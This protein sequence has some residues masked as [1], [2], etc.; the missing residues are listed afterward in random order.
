MEQAVLG[1]IM[2]EKSAMDRVTDIL[3]PES[4][5]SDA[6]QKVFSAIKS[7]SAKGSPIDLLTVVEELTGSGDLDAVGGVGAVVRLTNSVVSS[8]H[9]EAHA[10]VIDSYHVRREVIRAAGELINM[11]YDDGVS[12]K[13]LIEE[14]DKSI[15]RIGAGTLSTGIM[16]MDDVMMSTLEKVDYWRNM[17]SEVTGVPSG[18]REIDYSTRGW[19]PGDLI[20]LAARPSVGKTALSLN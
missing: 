4:F 2:L 1:A 16:N 17:G 20:I 13:Q 14:A 18:F 7:L 3:K 5:Y 12:G 19:Q 15:L 9:V 6:H 10:R 8:A 11:G